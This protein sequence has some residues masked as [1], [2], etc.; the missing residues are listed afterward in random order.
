MTKKIIIGMLILFVLSKVGMAWIGS[1][2]IE[3]NLEGINQNLIIY[4]QIDINDSNFDAFYNEAKKAYEVGNKL[5]LFPE[6]QTEVT[7]RIFQSI[8]KNESSELFKMIANDKFNDLDAQQALLNKIIPLLKLEERNTAK[9]NLEREIYSLYHKK[10]FKVIK[11]EHPSV[12][13]NKLKEIFIAIKK[14]SFLDY[15]GKEISNEFK[16]K[17][18]QVIESDI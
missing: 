16:D 7:S 9:E 6:S 3:E 8:V 14:D 17:L 10:I 2:E 1:K 13:Y 11:E 12:K 18:F 4:E 15:K 5:G